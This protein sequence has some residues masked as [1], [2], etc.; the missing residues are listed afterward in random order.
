MQGRP[1]GKLAKA[2]KKVLMRYVGK[3]KSNGKVFDETKGNKTFT[4]RLG[5]GEVIKGEQ[6]EGR[7]PWASFRLKEGQNA[8]GW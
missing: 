3:L 5:V 8:C 6:P 1:D 2:G 4:F 7:A